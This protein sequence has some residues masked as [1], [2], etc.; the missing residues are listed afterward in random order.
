MAVYGEVDHGRPW[1]SQEQPSTAEDHLGITWGPLGAPSEAC[2]GHN[3][4]HVW[5]M[6]EAS[7][8][9]CLVHHLGYV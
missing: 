2:L 9:E 6:Y 4:G 1:Q 8:G 3:L 5:D 7:S